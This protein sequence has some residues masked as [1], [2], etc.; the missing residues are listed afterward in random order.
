MLSG[1]V[2][3]IVCVYLALYISVFLKC[4]TYKQTPGDELTNMKADCSSSEHDG[5][6]NMWRRLGLQSCGRGDERLKILTSCTSCWD[7][8][9]YQNPVRNRRGLFL[10]AHILQ[11]VSLFLFHFGAKGNK[12]VSAM[13]LSP[14]SVRLIIREENS[15]IH[16]LLRLFAANFSKL[17]RGMQE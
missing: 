14:V 9:S 5:L 7:I 1:S 17:Q 2:E 16:H 13:T 10:Q 4:E 11:N 15:V 12:N 6:Q 8:G 3:S